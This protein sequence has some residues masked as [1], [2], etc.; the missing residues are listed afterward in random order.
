[1]NVFELSAVASPLAGAIAG[2]VSVRTSG[3]VPIS[4]GV[5]SGLVIGTLLFFAAVGFSFLLL[6][7]SGAMTKTEGLSPH[8]WIASLV[9]VLIPAASPFAAWALTALVVFKFLHL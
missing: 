5:I 9:G 6:R 2:C 3:L 7:V 8:Q 1:M 4:C